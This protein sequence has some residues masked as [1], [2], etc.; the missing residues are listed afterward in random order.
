MPV[1]IIPLCQDGKPHDAYWTL[2]GWIECQKCGKRDRR[3][4][5]AEFWSL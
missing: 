1:T 5:I 3:E 2:D 4:V